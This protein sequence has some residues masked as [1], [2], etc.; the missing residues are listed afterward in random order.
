MTARYSAVSLMALMLASPALAGTL[1]EI[2]TSA[3][4]QVPQCATPGRLM[5][6]LA[7][8]NHRLDPRFAS[9]ATEYM[10]HGEKLGLRWDVAFFQMM[11]E[12]ANLAYTGVVKSSQNNFAGLGAT[13]GKERG[14]TFADVSTGVKAHLQHI[15]MYAGQ[16]I[17]NP[18]AERTRKVQ[19]WGVL[20]KWQ[21]SIKGPM[22]FAH[23]TK[24]WAPGSGGY[25]RDIEAVAD[26]FLAGECKKADPRPELV[27]EARS[28][29]THASAHK[30][31]VETTEP[32]KVSGVEIA[33]QAIAEARA[34]GQGRSSLGAGAKAEQ[35]QPPT[36]PL[37]FKILN[38]QTEPAA[39]P[40]PP[41]ASTESK[42]AA[43]PSAKPP[44][45]EQLALVTDGAKALGSPAKAKTAKCNVWTASYGGHKAIIIKAM[46]NGATNYTV[47]DVNEGS[48][49]REA[50]AYISAYAKNGEAIG[51]FTDQNKALEKA[52]DLCPEG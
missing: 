24:Q 15:L 40:A 42:P 31:A 2:K 19:E 51:E 47:L 50:E 11:V 9:I 48:E 34:D 13:G 3:G 14:E 7:S 21:Q 44:A 17:D 4:N 6:Y 12:T 10:R 32:A 16:H 5:A 22:T 29:Q 36:S 45:K 30:A 8:R 46:A 35:P 37:P 33:R 27:A 43:E 49:K 28:G 41:R 18:V 39:T 26:A 1:P 20:T 23:L 25:R 52:F 38:G